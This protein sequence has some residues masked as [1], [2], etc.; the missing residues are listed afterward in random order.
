MS[1]KKYNVTN[2]EYK[3]VLRLQYFSI[4]ENILK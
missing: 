4:D 1:V 2:I 3:M